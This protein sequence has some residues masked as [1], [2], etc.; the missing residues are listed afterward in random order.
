MHIGW[1]RPID[2]LC[3][4]LYQFK[5]VKSKF[6]F[7]PEAMI[8]RIRIDLILQILP[9]G[10]CECHYPCTFRSCHCCPCCPSCRKS[11]HLTW[12]NAFSHVHTPVFSHT[13]EEN[14]FESCS[15]LMHFA[16]FLCIFTRKTRLSYTRKRNPTPYPT[17]EITNNYW[18]SGVW[19]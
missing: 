2:C 11:T 18:K 5:S 3:C 7:V 19:V 13:F 8:S 15:S 10:R 4:L 9:Y 12:G 6:I 1:A 14:W 16:S 17:P